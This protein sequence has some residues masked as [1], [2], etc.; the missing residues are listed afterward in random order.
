MVQP[1]LQGPGIPTARSPR[2]KRYRSTTDGFDE[3]FRS[4]Y[5]SIVG[6]VMRAGASREDAEEAVTDAMALAHPQFGALEKPAAWVRTV[7]VH[8]YVK[9]V[10]RDRKIR[11]REEAAPRPSTAAQP[12]DR[13][14]YLIVADV[15]RGLP[16]VQRTILALSIDG[17]APREIAELLGSS[18]DT[19]RS[20][21]RHARNAVAVALRNEGV[22]NG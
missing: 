21:L 7:A 3:F 22:R 12:E 5:R 10:V 4:D 8:L 17:Y 1:Q 16:R 18:P 11:Q 15:L 19:V 20:S 2:V 9:R 14:L 6:T 13:A